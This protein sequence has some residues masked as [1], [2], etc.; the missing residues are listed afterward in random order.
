MLVG[1]TGTTGAGK[2]TAVEMLKSRAGFSHFSARALIEETLKKEDKELSRINMISLADEWRKK[3]GPGYI[4]ET[5]ASRALAQGGNAIIES[6]RTLGEIESFR[7]LVPH[8]II[9]A[10]DAD[11]KLRY[12]RVFL[13]GASTDDISFEQFVAEEKKESEGKDVWRGNLPGCIL[14]AD[15]VIR[16]DGDKLAFE[17]EITQFLKT[18]GIN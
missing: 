18:H 1:I 5:L 6:I 17:K 9:L 13:R 11:E 14:R 4:V 3:Y 15:V 7:R 12:E 10:I 8:G 2:G 16:N